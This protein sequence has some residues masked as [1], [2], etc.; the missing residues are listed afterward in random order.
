L[1]YITVIAQ[2]VCIKRGLYGR[3]I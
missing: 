2:K 1:A 3:A